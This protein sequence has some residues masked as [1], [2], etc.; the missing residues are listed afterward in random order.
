MDDF[1]K[2]LILAY[3]KEKKAN[4]SLIELHELLGVSMSKLDDYLDE[5]FDSKLV[6]YNE[7]TLLSLSFEGR[8]LLLNNKME[9]GL[10]QDGIN[11]SK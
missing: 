4:Y 2:M 8:I 3:L 5:L 11:I 1:V 10:N 7:K 6:M 9:K